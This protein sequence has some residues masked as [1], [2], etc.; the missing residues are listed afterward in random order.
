[1]VL[2]IV[3]KVSYLVYG[4]ELEDHYN[5][6]VKLNDNK[7]L[8]NIKSIKYLESNKYRKMLSFIESSPFQILVMGHSC[9][10]SDRTL[11]NT[12][13]EHKKLCINKTLLLP[14]RRWFR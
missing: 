4:D 12:L 13:F 6:I 8:Q 3:L 1:M 7:C 14:K 5:E 11:L 10:N 9:G 2:L